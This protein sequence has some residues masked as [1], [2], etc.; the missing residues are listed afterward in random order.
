MNWNLALPEILLS[1]SGLLIL[2]FGLV[3]KKEQSA[4]ICT[5][6][7]IASFIACIFLV[8]TSS[9]GVAY[10]GAF[11]NDSFAKF[12]KIL[13]L[14]AA[15][16]T[17]ILATEFNG[18]EK[19]DKFEFPVLILF[20]T[21]GALIMASA[22]NLITLFVGLELS[23]LALYIL[24]AF[25]RDSILSAESGLK[26]FVLGSL[27]SG[28]LLYGASL[29]YGYTGTL[30]YRG[31]KSALLATSQIYPGLIIGIVFILIGL[32]F[33]LSAVPF[34]M[35]TPDV[36]QG[37]PTS[38]TTYLASAPKFAAF[39][40][41]LRVISGPF[42]HTY[43]QWQLLI[44]IISI[45]SI[46]VG[47]IAA[48]AQTNIKRL[49]AYSSIGH[50]GFALMGVAAATPLG[51]RGSLIYLTAYLFMNA[52]AFA[53]IAALR[54][55]GHAV[56]SIYDFAGMAQKNKSLA[57]AMA[58]FMFSMVGVPPLAGFFGKFMVFYAALSAHLYTLVIFALIGSIITAFYYLRIIKIMY[59][60]PSIEGIDTVPSSY[61]F[62]SLVTGIVTVA[63][64]LVL[65]PITM[66]AQSAASVLFN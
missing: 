23:S 50:M 61:S 2:L 66:A 11:I 4:F 58:I 8:G 41:L 29:V 46:L 3:Q 39:A 65:G 9:D 35:W 12:I 14:I 20:S 64:I 6:L 17:L 21:V 40:L 45:A 25:A 10:N 18:F 27:A 55:K 30:D 13:I 49:M 36:Y 16:F 43:Y 28:I 44:E 32:S 48:I 24:C 53:V 42:G 22:E 57:L 63:F 33:K 26:Y 60:D 19:I 51:L 37:A 54:R 56:E 59:F 52:G 5:M 34:H 47:A 15:I 1:A 62:I 7:T 38:V 31:I